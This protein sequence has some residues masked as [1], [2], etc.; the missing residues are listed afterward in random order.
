MKKILFM[1]S[2]LRGGGAE[3]VLINLVNNLN[4]EYEIT[5]FSLFDE[6]VNKKYLKDKVHY[7]FYFPKV[8]RG[9]R[10]ILQLLSPEFLYKCIV[11]DDYDIVV[12]FFQGPITRIVAGGKNKS[13]KLIQWIHNEFHDKKK[14]LS[15]YRSEE[16]FIRLQRCF[17]TTI[18]VSETV[19][20]T[21]ELLFP[22]LITKSQV[23]YNVIETEEI[24]KLSMESIDLKMTNNGVIKLIAVGRL[25]PQKGFERL[26]RIVSRLY[27]EGYQINLFILGTGELHAKLQQIIQ[28][29]GMKSAI[30]LLGYQDNPYAF[31]RNADLFVCS[32]LHE[33][34]STAVSES[35]IV[36]TPVIT[37]NCSGM[38][39]LL[40]TNQEYGKIVENSDEGLYEGLKK[41][42]DNPSEL[43]TYK[44]V[45]RIRGKHF[46]KENQIR[47][48]ERMLNE[49]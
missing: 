3:K 27:R 10:L 5:L 48:I 4:E 35:L 24:K 39:E 42:L 14:L 7:K 11:K 2:S 47:A 49:L 30:H 29:E 43:E 45:T 33:G 22:G 15:S 46:N 32:S 40:G 18:Y 21:Y 23:L 9:N 8:F 25:V 31:V 38:N 17:D 44:K 37:T 12:S 1:V 36:G 20:S 13:T 34:Y 41:L 6:G 26:I 28:T 16:E 19:K